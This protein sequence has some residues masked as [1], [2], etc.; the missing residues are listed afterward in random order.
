V[1][2]VDIRIKQQFDDNL[3]TITIYGKVN[4]SPSDT[5]EI[6]IGVSEG[7]TAFLRAE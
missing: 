6:Q 3:M 2:V 5:F 4:L 7:G 1:T